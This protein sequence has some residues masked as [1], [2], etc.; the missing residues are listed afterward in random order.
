MTKEDLIN[1]LSEDTERSCGKS[2]DDHDW[3][4]QI[5]AHNHIDEYLIDGSAI[6]DEWPNRI[7]H[8]GGDSA[9]VALAIGT[10]PDIAF[11]ECNW[12]A[13]KWDNNGLDKR[14]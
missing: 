8:V 4:I 13:I 14:E 5:P 3:T 6:Y 1:E 11:A 12:C 9:A 10:H 7:I 2:P